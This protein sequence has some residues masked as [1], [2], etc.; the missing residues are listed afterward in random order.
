MTTTGRFFTISGGRNPVLKSQ[1]KTW[2]GFGWKVYGLHNRAN[3][4]EQG[5]KWQGH[6]KKMRK[7]KRVVDRETN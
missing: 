3:I 4:H 7:N 1:I 2:P 5:V 6:R